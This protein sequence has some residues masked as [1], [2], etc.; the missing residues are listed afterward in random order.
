VD[1]KNKY[2][3]AM[4]KNVFYLLFLMILLSRACI[5]ATN[6]N[7]EKGDSGHLSCRVQPLGHIDIDTSELN[8]EKIYTQNNKDAL[9]FE[10][11]T[12][13]STEYFTHDSLI[14]EHNIFRLDTL[15]ISTLQ[16][17]YIN[18]PEK[19]SKLNEIC[20][21]A[22]ID[23]LEIANEMRRATLFAMDNTG[24]VSL[25]TSHYNDGLDIISIVKIG[26]YIVF[27]A[28]TRGASGFSANFSHLYFLK[29]EKGFNYVLYGHLF[30]KNNQTVWLK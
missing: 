19:T 24:Y 4:K 12:L 9:K 2:Y 5:Q 29:K 23:S 7:F 13:V 20:F 15:S 14:L 28:T 8:A 1:F 16:S 30:E 6:T 25:D 11:F 10:A 17:V 26:Q 21:N 27:S 22:P 3:F 18:R